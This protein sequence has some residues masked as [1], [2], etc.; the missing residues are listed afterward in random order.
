MKTVVKVNKGVLR[1]ELDKIRD[2]VEMQAKDHV[3]RIADFAVDTTLTSK[4]SKGKM[5]AVDTGAY[6]TSFSISYGRGRPRGK[7]SHRKPRNNPD[8]VGLGEVA[9]ADLY[10]D[11]SKIDF[12]DTSKVSLRNNSPHAELVEYKH[13]YYIFAKIEREFNG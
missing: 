6:I 12:F 9:R 10:S 4:S 8:L 7:S 3:K 1:S 5:G 2:H 13:G 11:I